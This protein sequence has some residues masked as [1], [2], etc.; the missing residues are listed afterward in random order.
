MNIELLGDG[1]VL[2]KS[3][4]YCFILSFCC[5]LRIMTTVDAL[6]N[7]WAAYAGPGGCY[8]GPNESTN[9]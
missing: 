9:H 4:S 5:C 6:H 2:F 8:S 1:L 7:K 3:W